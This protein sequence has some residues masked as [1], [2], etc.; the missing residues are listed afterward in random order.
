M[1]C[2]V[3]KYGETYKLVWLPSSDWRARPPDPEEEGAAEEKEAPEDDEEKDIPPEKLT[4]NIIRAK[5][6]I[7][8]LALC[9]EWQYF[10]TMTFDSAKQQRDNLPEIIKDFGHWIGNYNKKYN[11]KLR[12]IVVTETHKDGV[13]W[14]LHGLFGGIAPE[15]VQINEHGYY[16]M[17]YYRKRF[18]W[19]SLSTIKSHERVA[20]YITKY[21]S[22]DLTARAGDT[23]KHLYY[24]SHGLKGKEKLFAAPS[25]PM[26]CADYINDYC[27]IMWATREQLNDLLG[28]YLH[29]TI[30]DMIYREQLRELEGEENINRARE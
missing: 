9:N 29:T 26:S 11:S 21:V 22:K 24:A 16:D 23:G 28:Q 12:Y 5:S 10:V 7:R 8:E 4:N 30:D 25:V 2:N 19:I 20:A 27:G 18:G 17:P 13:N 6:R 15:S 1:I 3:Y 14:H